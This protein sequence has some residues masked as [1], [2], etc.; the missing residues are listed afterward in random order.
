MGHDCKTCAH[1][2]T[3]Y[4]RE[5]EGRFSDAYKPTGYVR[6]AGPRYNGRA[7]FCRD[8]RKACRDYERKERK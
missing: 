6:C 8:G 2:T 5:R 4:G 1:A 7:Y 3:L